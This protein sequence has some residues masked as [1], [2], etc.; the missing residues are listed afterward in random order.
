V[1]GQRAVD[2]QNRV[3]QS[4]QRRTGICVEFVS[5]PL[6]GLATPTEQTWSVAAEAVLLVA[7]TV[8]ALASLRGRTPVGGVT[9]DAGD[10]QG[11]MHGR[12]VLVP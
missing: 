8:A 4:L 10:E 12:R 6:Y 5:L 2:V 7:F 9:G 3:V 1:H 11:R